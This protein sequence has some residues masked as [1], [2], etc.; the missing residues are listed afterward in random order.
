[1][2]LLIK[3]HTSTAFCWQVGNWRTYLRFPLT[4]VVIPTRLTSFMYLVSNVNILLH[5]LHKMRTITTWQVGDHCTY[6]CPSIMFHA[7]N[8]VMHA[9]WGQLFGTF[10]FIS[11]QTSVNSSVGT[12]IVH[13]QDYQGTRVWFLAGTKISLFSKVSRLA[14]GP[15]QFLCCSSQGLC[16]WE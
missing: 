10:S 2:D 3:M 16:S 13:R 6:L 9:L 11:Y 7:L 12:V 8:S 5:S 15:I 4:A 14:L 1:M